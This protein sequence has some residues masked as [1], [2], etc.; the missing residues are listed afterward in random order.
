[1]GEGGCVGGVAVAVVVVGWGV[2]CVRACV[3]V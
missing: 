3:C 1:M 2:A